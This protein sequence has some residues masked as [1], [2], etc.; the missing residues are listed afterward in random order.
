MYAYNGAKEIDSKLKQEIRDLFEIKWKQDR[1]NSIMTET[2]KY[3]FD[4]LPSEVQLSIFKKFLFRDYLMQFRRL[5]SFRV[6]DSPLKFLKCRI[7]EKK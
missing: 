4:Q 6:E 1:N 2:D 5:F 7:D 3:L